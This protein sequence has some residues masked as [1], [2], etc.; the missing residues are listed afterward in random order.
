[1]AGSPLDKRGPDSYFPLAIP[2]PCNPVSLRHSLLYCLRLT[3]MSNAS[4]EK[5]SPDGGSTATH[6]KL[7]SLGSVQV[8]LLSL[9][10]FFVLVALRRRYFSSISD[11][12][13]LFISSISSNLWHIL[14]IIK[15]HLEAELIALHRKHSIF[16]RIS[17]NEVDVS[18]TDVVNK[19]LSARFR[20][21]SSF[22]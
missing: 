22:V 17:Y 12:P 7:S 18:H 16:V 21:V 6:L 10:V 4:F 19:I 20:K 5:Q 2:R 11:I 14:H 15:G 9:I 3:R 1:M 13:G 8:L